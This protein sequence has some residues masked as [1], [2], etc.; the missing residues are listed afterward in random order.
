VFE[1][2]SKEPTM[3]TSDPTDILLAHDRWATQQILDASKPLTVEQFAQRFDI[4]SGSLHDTIVHMLSAMRSWT[5]LLT[6]RELR[7]PLE[8][9]PRT[10]D[11]I[12]L[13]LDETCTDLA[14]AAKSRPL[15]ELV[16]RERGG[17]SYTFA[18]GAVI[19]HVTTHGMHHR[20]QCL[21]I[22]RRLG[23]TQQ[24]PSSVLQWTMMADAA[25]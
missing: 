7:P 14:T 24:P 5:D 25:K 23:V 16:T 21:N 12:Q 15:D 19:V 3:P 9:H 22:L 4:G 8:P 2:F 11:E 6:G 1:Q 18:R 20:A 10:V 13:M 17:K